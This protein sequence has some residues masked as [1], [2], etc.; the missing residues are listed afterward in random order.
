M[1]E[2]KNVLKCPA[3]S[4]PRTDGNNIPLRPCDTCGGTG[5]V[6]ETFGTYLSLRGDVYCFVYRPTLLDMR[7]AAPGRRIFRFLIPATYA[8]TSVETISPP[9]EEVK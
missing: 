7:A 1:L 8:D 2:G 6:V 5:Q 3:C 4:K 9:M